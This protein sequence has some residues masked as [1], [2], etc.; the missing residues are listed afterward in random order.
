[1]IAAGAPLLVL[2]LLPA[3]L[4]VLASPGQVLSEPASQLEDDGGAPMSQN[5]IAN[6][7]PIVSSDEEELAAPLHPT[8]PLHLVPAQAALIG[9]LGEKPQLIPLAAAPSGYNE[10]SSVHLLCTI[11][12][13]HHESLTFDW[14][15]DGQLLASSGASKLAPQVEKHPD[16]SLLRI[17]YVKSQHAG[18]YTCSARNQFGLDSSSVNLAVNGN[19]DG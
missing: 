3:L 14:F 7:N 9:G 4:L 11:S 13:G 15:K 2:L 18:R 10:N 19:Y 8:G 6:F 1:M 5:R 12:Q 17:E 16:H